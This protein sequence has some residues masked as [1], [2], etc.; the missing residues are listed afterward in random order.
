[1]KI[2]VY[3]PERRVG[4]LLDGFV[5][6]LARAAHGAVP[7]DL[8]AFIEAGPAATTAAAALLAELR[9]AGPKAIPD[10]VYDAATVTLHTPQVH[11]ARVACISGN[12]ADHT[13]GVDAAA[14]ATEGLEASELPGYAEMIAEIRERG[15][16]GFWKIARDGAGP[17]GRVPYPARTKLLDYESELAIVIGK[18]GKDI[19]KDE[20]ASYVWGVTL[21]QDYSVRD[22]FR[23]G[24]QQYKLDKNFDA[25]YGV[26]PCI[27]VGE[28]ID[29]NNAPIE[30]Y[31][32]GVQRQKFNTKDMIFKFDESLEF[33]SRDLTFY[34]GDIISGGT[35]RGT[36]MDSS[37]VV[38]GVFK[39]E[40]FLHV[41]DVI[42]ARSPAIGV[43][44][45]HIVAK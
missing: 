15:N 45:N 36:A 14:D 44:R 18:R 25:S 28:D 3:G 22:G 26:G 32:N 35:A 17:E 23:R 29:I 10:V 30:T 16:Y 20:L 7:A 19:R 9:L 13:Y 21:F 5:V 34:P 31:V 8:R 42:E 37:E 39:P 33:L 43:L 38:D 41:G 40:L 24:A 27:V 4:A 11:G 6:D 2:V 1:M 12:F